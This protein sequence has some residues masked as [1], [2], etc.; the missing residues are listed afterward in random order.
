MAKRREMLNQ[1]KITNCLLAIA[2]LSLAF[3]SA[4]G[5]SGHP[6]S[7]AQADA[8]AGELDA[9]NKAVATDPRNKMAEHSR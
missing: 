8:S 4:V 9:A 6:A 1:M 5:C 7:A 2:A 3:L